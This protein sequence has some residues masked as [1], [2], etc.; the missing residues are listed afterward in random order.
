MSDCDLDLGN[1]YRMLN[2]KTI[3]NT[4]NIIEIL[5]E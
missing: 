3:A 2:K 4:R 1:R 5:H